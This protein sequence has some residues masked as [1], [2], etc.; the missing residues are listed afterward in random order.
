[1]KKAEITIRVKQAF[2]LMAGDVPASCLNDYFIMDRAFC[3]SKGDF[4]IMREQIND[5]FGVAIPFKK[6]EDASISDITDIIDAKINTIK[7]DK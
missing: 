3:L 5:F 7:K 6:F 1:M 2:S 4:K